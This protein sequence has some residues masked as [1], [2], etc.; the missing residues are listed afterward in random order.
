MLLELT[1]TRQRLVADVTASR[2]AELRRIL[3]GLD[4]G[5]RAALTVTVRRLVD[6][7]GEGYGPIPRGL[8]PL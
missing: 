8:V 2:R 7:A 3:L 6:A 4:A 5:D 1:G